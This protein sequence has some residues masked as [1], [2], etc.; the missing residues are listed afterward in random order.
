MKFEKCGR[1]KVVP[2][3]IACEGNKVVPV[4]IERGGNKVVPVIIVCGGNKVVPVII[5]IREYIKRFSLAPTPH[6][7]NIMEDQGQ[8]VIRTYMRM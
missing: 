4:I 2:V 7:R 8:V 3:I 6:H 5:Q 1:N